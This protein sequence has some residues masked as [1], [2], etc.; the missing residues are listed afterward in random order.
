MYAKRTSSTRY[1]IHVIIHRATSHEC[2]EVMCVLCRFCR[3][4]LLTCDE[5]G[6]NNKSDYLAID[7]DPTVRH[8]QYQSA[9]ERVSF[10]AVYTC[11]CTHSCTWVCVCV[12]VC[13]YVR[14]CLCVCVC[15]CVCMHMCVYA[16]ICV[17]VHAYVCVCMHMC[18]YA[19]ICV[20]MHAYVSACENTLLYLPC[21]VKIPFCTA[22]IIEIPNFSHTTESQLSWRM[23]SIMATVCT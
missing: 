18:V 14:A 2:C 21:A 16:C 15:V 8:L 1:L 22:F 6:F 7:W 19:C 13:V 3:G 23:N 12:S 17:C 11:I 9:L 20:C 10:Y 4:C 5:K